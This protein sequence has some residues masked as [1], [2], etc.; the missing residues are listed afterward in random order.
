[1]RSAIGNTLRRRARNEGHR[2]ALG[3]NIVDLPDMKPRSDIVDGIM[4][5]LYNASKEAAAA[6]GSHLCQKACPPK[7]H[8]PI[9][10]MYELHATRQISRVHRR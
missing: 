4:R 1:M 10:S 7:L 3:D 5:P 6:H 8:Q 2:N 9:G